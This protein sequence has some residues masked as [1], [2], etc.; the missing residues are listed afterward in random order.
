MVGYEYDIIVG[1]LFVII[2]IM[3]LLDVVLRK[4]FPKNRFV[5]LPWKIKEWIEDN[6]II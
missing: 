5:N 3:I 2:L 6:I 1:I 4:F